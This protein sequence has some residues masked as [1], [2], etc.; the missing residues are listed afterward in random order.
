MTATQK[1][2]PRRDTLNLLVKP[3]VR[4]LI[5]RAAQMVGKSRTDFVLDAAQRAAE[6]ALLHR[7]LIRMSPNDFERFQAALDD[8][9]PPSAE[10]R[11]ALQQPAPWEK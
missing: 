11:K 6:E 3:A 2:L 8:P 1:R 4:G 5:D 7:T 9:S 10:L